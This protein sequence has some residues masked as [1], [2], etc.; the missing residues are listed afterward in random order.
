MRQ[1]EATDKLLY[2]EDLDSEHVQRIEVY[3]DRHG[4]IFAEFTAKMGDSV[5]RWCEEVDE[6]NA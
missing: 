1:R 2:A 6:H 5:H 4:I 3:R